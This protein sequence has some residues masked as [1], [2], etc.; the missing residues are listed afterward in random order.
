MVKRLASTA[1]RLLLYGTVGAVC[2]WCIL[3]L[4]FYPPLPRWLGALLG[5]VF[6]A[7]M[8]VTKRR[9][10]DPRC[11]LKFFGIAALSVVLAWLAIRPTHEQ[12]WS[13]GHAIM[14]TAEFDGDQVTLHNIR[15]TVHTADSEP[16]VRYS[17]R[18]YELDDLESVWL[19]V[20]HFASWEGVAHT[21]VSFGF[22]DGRY[23]A[24]SIEARRCEGER[25]SALAGL[26]KQ[27]G[28]I[29]VVGDEREIIGRRALAEEGPLYLYPIHADRQQMQAMLVSVLRRANRLAEEP[30]FY[31]T[32]TNNCTTNILDS[33]N[34]I[35]PIH[36]SPYSPRI[37]FPGY[38]GDV[39]Y[40]QRLIDTDKPFHELKAAAR[41]DEAARA[42]AEASD[43]SQKIREQFGRES[44]HRAARRGRH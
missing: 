31:N 4:F 30:E 20:Q 26:F 16:E 22:T 36:I 24:V 1:G 32:L 33:F 12:P 34:Q 25:Y 7:G 2:L 38:S 15:W 37:V 29:Y 11:V 41:I 17:D 35:A 43:F 10:K 8:V 42:A 39:A 23:L 27:F 5:V 3:A 13:A 18:T 9:V 6:A 19:G 28:V 40:D 21:F 14:P 44:S